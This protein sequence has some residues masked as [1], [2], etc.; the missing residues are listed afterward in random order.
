M[1][2]NITVVATLTMDTERYEEV[3]QKN[4]AEKELKAVNE[5]EQQLKYMGMSNAEAADQVESVVALKELQTV[6]ANR[7][8]IMNEMREMKQE[9][10]AEHLDTRIG[11][12]RR[13][14]KEWH[15]QGG[16][17]VSM[18][19]KLL[20]GALETLPDDEQPLRKEPEPGEHNDFR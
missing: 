18:R 10:S 3:K 11:P 5:I 1:T 4:A 16:W 13:T 12:E 9:A 19:R 8:R 2:S 7:Q 20:Y 15:Q 17:D 6:E 14:I